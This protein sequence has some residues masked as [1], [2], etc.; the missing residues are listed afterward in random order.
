M[1]RSVNHIISESS[2]NEVSI[3]QMQLPLRLAGLG[4]RRFTPQHADAAYIAAAALTEVLLEQGAPK[5]RP[6]RGGSGSSLAR[7][8]SALHLSGPWD[9]A[10]RILT[11]QVI[12]DVLPG[13]QYDFTKYWDAKSYEDMLASFGTA[14]LPGQFA[15]ARLR[16]CACREA[17][18]WLDTLPTAS[19][20]QL[21]DADFRIGLRLGLGLSQY[22]ANAPQTTCFCGAVL[23]ASNIDHAMRCTS[24]RGSTTLRHNLVS[25]TWRRVAHRAG[26]ATSSEPLLRRLGDVGKQDGDSRADIMVVLPKEIVVGDISVT[27]PAATTYAA[28][29]SK[30]DGA[31]AAGREH[32]KHRRY[33]T[34]STAYR[35]FALVHESFGRLGQEGHQLLRMLA[36]TAAGA[37][38]ESIRAREFLSNAYRELSVSL[39]RGKGILFRAS[40]YTF[41]RASGSAITP[42]LTCPTAEVI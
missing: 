1:I 26:I 10:D 13:A 33:P 34:E 25:A 21:S 6:F 35:L 27:H 14:T 41:A 31:A 3:A 18:I 17:S 28:A 9:A 24:L 8:W 2:P 40:Q 20:L 38:I 4:L 5:L 22:P 19:F 32:A 30:E 7:I 15:S 16:S 39:I 36:N 37:S 29:A 23:R 12:R 11:D 42:G